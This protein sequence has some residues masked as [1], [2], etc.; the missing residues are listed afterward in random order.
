[1]D[2]FKKSSVFRTL[3]NDYVGEN[4]GSSRT[5]VYAV[6]KGE[7]AVNP[8]EGDVEGDTGDAGE[9]DADMGGEAGG[10]T[11]A[12]PEADMGDT[13]DEAGADTGGEDLGL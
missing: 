2:E 8:A 9:I 11:E 3:S 13:G 10:D 6:I 5:S 1:M 12:D 7:E 4:S